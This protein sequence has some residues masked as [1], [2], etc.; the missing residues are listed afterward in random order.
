[1][2]AKGFLLKVLLT[3]A[4][5]LTGALLLKR[6][7]ERGH[8]VYALVRSSLPEQA[9]LTVLLA[10]LSQDQPWP[11]L[12]TS[13][14]AVVH[15]AQSLE[16]RHFP[17]KAAQVFAVNVATTQKLL[18]YAWQ[19]GAQSFV[20]ASTGSVY[21]RGT[22]P[23]TESDVPNFQSGYYAASKL[24]AELLAQSYSNQFA[25]SIFRPFTIYGLGQ[26]SDMLIPRLIHS[27][28]QGLPVRLEGNEGMMFNP[29]WAPEAAQVFAQA[30]ELPQSGVFNLAGPQVVSL[31]Q[32][33]QWIGQALGQEPV[34][35][36]APELAPPYV[37]G[38]IALLQQHWL[39]PQVGLQQGLAWMLQHRGT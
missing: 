35:E 38:D 21:G 12:P 19:A 9:G 7:L 33:V 17:Q 23:F 30:A 20:L 29:I 37:A 16:F 2:V 26:R 27:V 10:D 13:I 34:F 14:D 8:Q 39:S 32:A 6:L 1:M 28:R 31:K 36:Y 24:S 4:S 22:R 15:L 25:V 11:P 18:H 5:G 3:G